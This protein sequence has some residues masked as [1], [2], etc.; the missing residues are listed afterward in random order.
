MFGTAL[1][2]FLPSAPAW[3]MG[4]RC[5]SSSHRGAT[6]AAGHCHPPPGQSALQP[7]QRVTAQPR[8]GAAAPA[9]NLEATGRCRLHPT[10]IR[11]YALI[12]RGRGRPPRAAGMR[13][14]EASSPPAASQPAVPTCTG[15]QAVSERCQASECRA[16]HPL[17]APAPAA[18][19]ALAWAQRNHQTRPT[20]L[21]APAAATAASAPPSAV[22]PPAPLRSRW[23]PPR[24]ARLSRIEQCWGRCS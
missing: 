2:P 23:R 6:A 22:A 15:S 3:S 14:A 13:S 12:R 5:S 7:P 21:G 4:R 19:G 24:R 9:S 11:C 16:R 18:Q 1:C 8:L 20:P 17:P 10:A